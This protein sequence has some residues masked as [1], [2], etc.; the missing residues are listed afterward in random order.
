MERQTSVIIYWNFLDNKIQSLDER[1]E[2]SVIRQGVNIY[3]TYHK[4]K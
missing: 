4:R 2:Y 1:S 3:Y